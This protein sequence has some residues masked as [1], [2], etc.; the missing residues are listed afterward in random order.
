[1]T[2]T[3]AP[4]RG[5]CEIFA[6]QPLPAGLLDAFWAYETALLGN[7]HATLNA[8]FAPGPPDQSVWSNTT[9]RE[10]VR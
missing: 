10:R 3:P 1:M 8:L 2:S 4:A 6:P 7:D 9:S 5:N